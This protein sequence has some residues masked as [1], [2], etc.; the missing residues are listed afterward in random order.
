[1]FLLVLCCFYNVDITSTCVG[2]YS[3]GISQGVRSS[4]GAV[5]VAEERL[6]RLTTMP[7]S[8]YVPIMTV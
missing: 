3:Q 8:G 7:S 2:W 1:M 6:R 5:R 4:T